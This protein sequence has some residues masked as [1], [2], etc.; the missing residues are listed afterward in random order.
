[1]RNGMKRRNSIIIIIMII[2]ERKTAL[3]VCLCLF[4]CLSGCVS[5]CLPTYVSVC[6]CISFTCT[7]T[8]CRSAYLLV[9]FWLS[10]S[11]CL[12]VAFPSCPLIFFQF[13]FFSLSLIL[14]IYSF[15]FTCL[16][17]SY[18]PLPF[19]NPPRVLLS[20]ILLILLFPSANP[21]SV[22]LLFLLLT[23]TNPPP[24]L[25]SFFLLSS[26]N[27]PPILLYFPL[28]QT[29]NPPPMLN[30]SAAVPSI[31]CCPPALLSS[32][33]SVANWI[34]CTN[35]DLTSATINRQIDE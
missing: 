28:L 24:I 1:M 5:L 7:S 15:G 16:Q 31:C 12:S 26:T 25:F 9:F 10:S 17:S 13:N 22:L 34:L 19:A 20:I 29:P 4:L 8:L 21:P 6:L 14:H 27:S 32:L 3:S 35:G 33:P 23:S 11:N 2:I 18:F 30:Y